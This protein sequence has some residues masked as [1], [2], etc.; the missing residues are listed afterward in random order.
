MIYSQHTDPIICVPQHISRY[1]MYSAHLILLNAICNYMYNY[2][3]IT[4]L[5]FYYTLRLCCIGIKYKTLV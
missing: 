4:L 3:S 5:E 2:N 1:G